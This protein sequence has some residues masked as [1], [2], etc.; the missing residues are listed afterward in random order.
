MEW[1]DAEICFVCGIFLGLETIILLIFL[2]F[3]IGGIIGVILL[4]LNK[5]SPK[6]FI[7][8]GPFIAVASV[9]T[10]LFYSDIVRWY[11]YIL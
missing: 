6:D 9:I 1:D 10:T 3:I 5:K 7:P 4:S 2:S 8:F 11:L